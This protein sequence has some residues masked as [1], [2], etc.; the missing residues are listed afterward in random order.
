MKPTLHGAAMLLVLATAWQSRAG[1]VIKADNTIE[2]GLA[3]SYTPETTRTTSDTIVFNDTLVN[4]AT[5]SWS[6]NRTARGLR[7]EDP[8]NA[9]AINLSAATF[10]LMDT[11]DGTVV[12]MTAATTNLTIAASNAGAAVRVRGTSAGG[13]TLAVSSGRTLR[14]QT[15]LLYNNISNGTVSTIHIAGAG[16]VTVDGTNGRITDKGTG[17]GT[18]TA[19]S[20]EGTGTVTLAGASTYSGGTTLSS[21]TLVVENAKALGDGAVTVGGGTLDLNGAGVVN[22]VLADGKDFTFS[23]GTLKLD[24][25]TSFDQIT[26]GGAGKLNLTGGTFELTLGV[27]FDYGIVYQ[28][29]SGFASGTSTVSGLTFTGFDTATYQASLNTLGELSFTAIPEPSTYA[30]LVGGSVLAGAVLRRR[31]PG[32]RG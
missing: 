12:D 23:E 25:G 21:G 27:G 5:F 14:I 8:A 32:K 7:L 22:L 29:F 2:L 13:A 28:L 26:G 16:N 19:L 4:N 10:D 30:V 6:S 24:L 20:H 18:L 31:R 17:T 11:T 9:V 3:T 1:D 15:N